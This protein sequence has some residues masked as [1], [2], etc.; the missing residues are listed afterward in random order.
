[1]DTIIKVALGVLL[2]LTL[3][4]CFPWL[5]LLT[6]IYWNDIA[7]FL[8]FILVLIPGS[9]ILLFILYRARKIIYSACKIVYSS[10]KITYSAHRNIIKKIFK[11]L[12]F[13]F[14]LTAILVVCWLTIL[15][16][17]KTINDRFT[18]MKLESDYYWGRGIVDCTNLSDKIVHILGKNLVPLN[19]C[20]T[21]SQTYVISWVKDSCG[22][23]SPFY[24][25]VFNDDDKLIL[26]TDTG[27]STRFDFIFSDSF[28]I[29]QPMRISNEPCCCPSRYKR[30]FF[31][32]IDNKYI[33][34]RPWWSYL[35]KPEV[36]TNDLDKRKQ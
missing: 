19:C 23:C 4:K 29:I 32:L 24:L 10:C 25:H 6:T 15:G 7:N 9:I 20:V 8:F 22:S 34:K 13:V 28:S 16:L 26:E 1:M 27:N 33:E 5:I 30:R 11:V 12:F 17:K 18:T 35:L 14:M 2:G 31:V 36:L 21:N 3:W